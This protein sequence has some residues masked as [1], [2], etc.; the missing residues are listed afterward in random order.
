MSS[1]NISSQPHTDI[2]NDGW[3]DK[4]PHG[5]RPYLKLGR[6][7]RPIGVWLTLFPAYWA[8][9]LAAGGFAVDHLP[10]YLLFLCGAI[11]IRAAGCVINDLWDRELDKSV[12]RTAVRP[13]ASG[14]VSVRQAIIFLVTLLAGAGLI[15]LQLPVK[16][17][18]VGCFAIV[19]II[20]YPLMK[21]ITYWPQLFL[22]VTFNLSV[23][24]GWFSIRPD[25]TLTPLL[26]YIAAIFW[27]IGFDTIYAH[28]DIEDDL[29][30]GI[31]STAIR[32]GDHSKRYVSLFYTGML[33][34]L[35]A[36]FLPAWYLALPGALYATWL[37]RKWDPL[38]LKNCLVTFKSN[39]ILGLIIWLSLICGF[40][41]F[42]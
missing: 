23:F 33:G 32:F 18:L 14:A 7:D 3:V 38:D 19:P 22:G 4:M 28:Q 27:T 26:L 40:L 34:L 1:K 12:A 37:I 30:I 17:I 16:A 42:H 25:F 5:W 10:L 21:R 15:L 31:K 41:L 8:M 2:R 11:L 9:T 6:F 36:A 29:K 24:I 35:T 13:L 39:A 20:L